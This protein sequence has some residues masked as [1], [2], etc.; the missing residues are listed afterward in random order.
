VLDL[1]DKYAASLSGS[2][3]VY[4]PKVK[5]F[6]DECEGDFSRRAVERHLNRLREEGYADG[7]IELV[8][9]TLKRFYKVN[10]LEWPFRPM[11]RPTIREKEVFAPALNPMLVEAMIRAAKRGRLNEQETAM[12]V[13]STTYGLRRKELAGLRKS[14]LRP[15]ERL[16]FVETAKRGR[17]RYHIVPDEIL[18]YLERYSFPPVS[19][20]KVTKIY[21]SIEKKLGLERMA[22][23]GWHAIRRI[24]NRLLVEAG[25]PEPV[26]MSFLRWKRSH[27]SM[28]GLYFSVT[29][30]GG[31]EEKGVEVARADREVDEAVFKVHPFVPLWKP[32]A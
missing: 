19:E 15:A 18:P 29:I 1:L 11:E 17:Q 30:V 28:V 8:F 4:L 23:V 9:K 6:L 7:T 13:L 2:R 16:L 5:R 22:E 27:R 24:L 21:Y 31:P 20:M 32:S 26:I 14:D 12:L 25:L 10:G 3:A